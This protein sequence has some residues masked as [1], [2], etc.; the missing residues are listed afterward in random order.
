MKKWTEIGIIMRD[1]AIERLG[2]S[3]REMDNFT[4]ISWSAQDVPTKSNKLV[5]QIFATGLTRLFIQREEQV[6]STLCS[7]IEPKDID[8]LID[9]YLAFIKE[10][11]K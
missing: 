10:T 3:Y 7:V 11:E 4:R 9:I 6:L 5:L 2:E 8:R 1:R